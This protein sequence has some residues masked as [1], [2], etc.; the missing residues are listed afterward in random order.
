[1]QTVIEKLQQKWNELTTRERK[2]LLIGGITITIGL[3]YI[4]ILNPLLNTLPHLR[5]EI[6]KQKELIQWMQPIVQRIQQLQTN[7]IALENINVNNQ[8][9][10]VM[11]EQS[12][13]TEQIDK[14]IKQL[15]QTTENQ[16]TIEF[17]TIPFD[18]LITWL[19][20]I[21]SSYSIGVYQLTIIP[22]KTPGLVQA[23]I[24]LQIDVG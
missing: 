11:L 16:I 10:L 6:Q 7:G 14:Y 12:I 2:L 19:E 23:Q 9:L 20:K 13:Q 3:F 1:M 17:N 22:D 4:S 5:Q 18:Q 24:I 21:W 8:S 15:R